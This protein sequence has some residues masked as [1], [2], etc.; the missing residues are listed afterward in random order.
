[1]NTVDIPTKQFIERQ[2]ERGN[3][4]EKNNEINNLCL[5]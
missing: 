2:R 4:R 3:G 1:M 5:K